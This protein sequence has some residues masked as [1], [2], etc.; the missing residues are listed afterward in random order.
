MLLPGA[1]FAVFLA[2]C[3]IAWVIARRRWRARQSQATAF[4]HLRLARLSDD[5]LSWY[6]R[7]PLAGTA[8]AALARHPA[9]RSRMT[10]GQAAIGPDDDPEF[11]RELARRI[12]G[13]P[14][15]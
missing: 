14:P 2:G 1:I 4:D 3:S 8:E 9:S 6:P 10:E 5:D 13:G 12:H 11:L 7:P 15:E